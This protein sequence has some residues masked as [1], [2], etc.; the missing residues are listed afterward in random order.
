HT[1][2][3]PHSHANP[4]PCFNTRRDRYAD[5]HAKQEIWEGSS[6]ASFAFAY[7]YTYAYAN[8]LITASTVDANR[9]TDSGSNTTLNRNS[10][11][12]EFLHP[13]TQLGQKS[14]ARRFGL[15][16]GPQSS[17]A[18]SCGAGALR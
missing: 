9:R 6:S 4:N 14:A 5:A 13:C 10:E 15:I 16:D 12:A 2:R 18:A 11:R 8:S 3:H 1:N 7:T 17:F